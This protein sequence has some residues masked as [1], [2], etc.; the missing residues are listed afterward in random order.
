MP[1]EKVLASRRGKHRRKTQEGGQTETTSTRTPSLSTD[2]VASD[3]GSDVSSSNPYHGLHSAVVPSPKSPTASPNEGDVPVCVTFDEDY[4]NQ[5]QTASPQDAQQVPT[6]EGLPRFIAPLPSHIVTKDVEFLSQKDAFAMPDPDTCHRILRSY[7]FSIHPFMPILDIQSIINAV[8]DEGKESRISLLLFQAVMFA[9][10]ASVDSNVV[11]GLGFESTKQAREVFFARV[12]LLYEFDIEPDEVAVLQSLLLMSWW[13]GSWKQRR[14]T[15]HW[16]GLALSSALSLGLHRETTCSSSDER[17]FRR[18]LWWSLYIRDRLLA[19]GTRRPMRIR[20]DSFHVP[21]LTLEDFDLNITWDV[22]PGTDSTP[23]VEEATRIALMCIELAKLCIRI[24]HVLFSQ[25]TTLETPANVAPTMMVV[26]KRH[27]DYSISELEVCDLEINE[28]FQ[29]LATNVGRQE[30]SQTTNRQPNCSE[31]HWSLLNILHLTLVNV[32]HR[33]HAIQSPSDT[34]EAQAVQKASRS[35]VKD[36]ARNV[37]RLA[38]SM[39]RRDQVRYM[40]VPGVTA[41]IAASLSHMPDIRSADEDVRDASI[42][43]FYQSMQV[44]Q[45]LRCIYASA[46]SAVAFLASVIRKTGISVPAQVVTPTPDFMSTLNS[47]PRTNTAEENTAPSID[48]AFAFQGRRWT[49]AHTLPTGRVPEWQM[50]P[51]QRPQPLSRGYSQPRPP[52]NLSQEIAPSSIL[53]STTPLALSHAPL[54]VL[55]HVISD[56]V[57]MPPLGV[58]DASFYEWNN[59]LDFGA[60]LSPNAAFD[61]DF[62]SDTFGLLDS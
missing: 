49:I 11:R 3:A 39:L 21:M 18:R 25:Y 8:L 40:G 54:P 50:P 34:A 1:D 52:P 9:G 32:L 41:L 55:E 7:V 43:R 37:T 38:H 28:W 36:A 15:W 46:D 53:P 33:T 42:L 62:C 14:H 26:P 57:N 13:Y 31:V 10:L 58:T 29:D 17:H 20:D 48:A 24:G 56:G 12:R 47:N 35:K 22:T 51:F 61:F 2:K 59:T 60:N 45:A 19:L 16:T 4:H 6:P 23:D 5:E 30:V 44:L 27:G